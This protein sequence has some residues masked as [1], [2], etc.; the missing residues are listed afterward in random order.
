M[1]CQSNRSRAFVSTSLTQ[2]RRTTFEARA[3]A[4]FETRHAIARIS[5]VS[6]KRSR[7]ISAN[8]TRVGRLE[9]VERGSCEVDVRMRRAK[10]TW[11]DAHAQEGGSREKKEKLSKHFRDDARSHAGSG[12]STTARGRLSTIS[13]RFVVSCT[14][15][16]HAF[17]VHAPRVPGCLHARIH[18]D[19]RIFTAN[20]SCVD[21]AGT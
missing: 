19:R 1:P 15:A 13:R 5:T 9:R 6:A 2:T 10:T 14:G 18:A 7:S 17:A 21:M 3:C 8:V 4:S 12:S 16:M 11:C 20:P